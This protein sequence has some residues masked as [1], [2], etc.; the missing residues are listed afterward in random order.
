MARLLAGAERIRFFDLR[1]VY[2]VIEYPDGTIFV[3][4]DFPSTIVTIT[5]NGRTKRV[6]DYVG[7]PDFLVQVE[8]EIDEAARTSR[9]TF[10]D[11]ETLAELAGWLVGV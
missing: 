3:L 4:S 9:W 6:E 8:R 10:L 7:A 2:R 5:V 1:D 11:E